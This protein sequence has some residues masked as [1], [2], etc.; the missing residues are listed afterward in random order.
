MLTPDVEESLCFVSFNARGLRNQKKT[1]TFFHHIRLEHKHLAAIL[2]QE[3][4][5]HP[6]TQN[7][8]GGPWPATS[9]LSSLTSAAGGVS[10]HLNPSWVTKMPHPPAFDTI[11][12]GRAISCSITTMEGTCCH[13]INIY[14]PTKASERNIFFQCIKTHIQ[15]KWIGDQIII[16]GDFNAVLDPTL[17]RR[18]QHQSAQGNTQTNEAGSQGLKD[19]I[20]TLGLQDILRIQFPN[21]ALYTCREVSRIDRW[22]ATSTTAKS[23]LASKPLPAPVAS[24]HA[25]IMLTINPQLQLRRGPGT[26]K[27][28]ERT[29]RDPLV[30]DQI[31]SILKTANIHQSG[32]PFHQWLHVKRSIAATLQEAGQQQAMQRQTEIKR[33]QDE[34]NHLQL[35]LT[36][37]HKGDRTFLPLRA[38]LHQCQ[39]RLQKIISAQY[40][41]A[42]KRARVRHLSEGEQYTRYFLSLAKIKERRRSI[43]T[44]KDQHGNAVSEPKEKLKVGTQFYQELYDWK[45]SNDEASNTLL[46]A[47]PSKSKLTS[48]QQ[49]VVA[50]PFSREEI[51]NW[52]GTRLGRQKSPGPDGLTG[53]FYR[54]FQEDLVPILHHL[55]NHALEHPKTWSH[56]FTAS[57]ICLLFKKGDASNIANYRPIAL[58][59]SDYKILTGTINARLRDLASHMLL[60]TQSGFTP[61]RLITDCIHVVDL[62]IH[63]LNQQNSPGHMVFLDQEKAYD[64][65]SHDWLHKCLQH[66]HFPDSITELIVGLNT[67]ATTRILIDGFVSKQVFQHSGVR[68]G[69][70]LSPLLYNL[71][72]EP[73]NC[74]LQSEAHSGIKGFR[75]N[76]SRITNVHYA[77]DTALAI[78]EGEGEAFAKALRLYQ[79]ASGARLNEAKGAVIPVGKRNRKQP[80]SS[81]LPAP[82]SKI[83]ILSHKDQ[84][85]YL[86]VPV[87]HRPGRSL[88]QEWLRRGQSIQKLIQNWTPR[89]TTLQGRVAVIN[90]L[91]YSQVYYHGA[92][93]YISASG[94]KKNFTRSAHR[95]L[96]KNRHFHPATH[97]L[98]DHPKHGGFNLTDLV[99]RFAAL[100]IKTLCTI[101]TRPDETAWTIRTLLESMLPNQGQKLVSLLHGPDLAILARMKLPQFWKQAIR[102]T[103]STLVILSPR[104]PTQ[105]P[106]SWTPLERQAAFLLLP[107]WY[108][109]ALNT[110]LNSSAQIP[111]RFPIQTIGDLK[112]LSVEE[113]EAMQGLPEGICLTVVWSLAQQWAQ[114]L[115]IPLLNGNSASQT[116]PLPN[117][118]NPAAMLGYTIRTGPQPAIGPVPLG[119]VTAKAAYQAIRGPPTAP[120]Q[121]PGVWKGLEPDQSPD[122]IAW[123]LARQCI[124][125]STLPPRLKESRWRFCMGQIPSNAI[126]QQWDESTSP[127]CPMCGN[128][129]ETP[130]HLVWQCPW[131]AEMWNIGNRILQQ[132]PSLPNNPI[133]RTEAIWSIRSTFQTNMGR[134]I[135]IAGIGLFIWRQRWT[136]VA[137]HI[138]SLPPKYHGTLLIADLAGIFADTLAASNLSKSIAPYAHDCPLLNA[139]GQARKLTDIALQTLLPGSHQFP[140]LNAF[141]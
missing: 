54:G 14:A 60:P 55:Y 50:K 123:N 132:W 108:Q 101:L 12:P 7:V 61:G 93:R 102:D 19:F 62:T 63:R 70:P 28:N 15:S 75:I 34:L 104:E 82:F 73:L 51:R 48:V 32:D 136:V 128:P 69:C 21:T 44:L 122:I 29:W 9:Y 79:A 106:D 84:C 36:N 16:G 20:T 98:Y 141:L 71:T 87:P 46:Q 68:Q 80:Q 37:T 49:E 96:W 114:Q 40:E 52:I 1:R 33:L 39:I 90:S 72:L 111:L 53:E 91:M 103:H 99:S 35:Q 59:N 43:I 45:A 115:G 95:F 5:T 56:H 17:D 109:P 31:C 6:E 22:Y 83:P 11:V 117:V 129:S 92:S 26:W 3:T 140:S 118:R 105:W 112:Q 78:P 25:M 134:S 4:H 121:L 24:D 100:R 65:V 133:T 58:L 85:Q 76:G 119:T 2:L 120:T 116:D 125:R 110:T 77:D 81:S 135:L 27:A 126:R 64:R 42:A 131:A 10:I 74:Y 13:I 47:V 94:I 18:P 113:R 97:F 57:Q 137:D 130:E 8:P 138:P 107:V 66:W 124:T 127:S 30:R 86:G 88:E 139:L 23:C 67:T 38:Q 89:T 41:F